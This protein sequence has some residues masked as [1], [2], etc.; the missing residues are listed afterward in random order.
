[1]DA[2]R[3]LG[4]LIERIDGDVTELSNFFSQLVI[5]VL[6]N[7][8]LLF[9]ILIAMFF[10]DWRL[11]LAFTVFSIL[12]MLALNAVRGLAIP[13]QKK[14]REAQ[15]DFFGYLEERLAGTEDIRS[16]GAVGFSLR[17]LHR[18]QAAIQSND[19]KAQVKN[20]AISN[21]TASS[22]TPNKSSNAVRRY[23]CS[24]RA[25]SDVSPP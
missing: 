15:A 5:R 3:V 11:G 10:V 7:I 9:G 16:S 12:T 19:W 14:F 25:N 13:F 22:G 6:G 24:A 21:L 23:P 8:L 4:E 17:E 18:L 1:M 2:F 20:W